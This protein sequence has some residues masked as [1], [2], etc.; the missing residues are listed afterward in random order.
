MADTSVFFWPS[1]NAGC[2]LYRCE[3]PAAALRRRGHTVQVS[4][5]ISGA[6]QI[7]EFDVVV[8]Q[9][10]CEPGPSSIWRDMARWGHSKLVLELDDDMWHLEP[11]NPASQYFTPEVLARLQ[12]NIALAD[13]VTVST[14]ALAE[15][16]SEWND[17]VVVLPNCIEAELLERPVLPVDDVVTIGWAGSPT[18]SRD[19]GEVAKPLRRV[20]QKYPDI[21]EFHCIGADYTDRCASIRGR[22]RFSPWQPMDLYYDSLDFHIGIAPLHADRFNESKSHIKLLEYSALGIAPVVSS[23][24]PYRQAVEQ[25]HP[26]P[27][28][29]T[30]KQ[31][32]EVLEALVTDDD[33]RR[34]L[35]D[36][37]RNWA[38]GY[39]IDRR[40]GEWEEAYA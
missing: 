1:D 28:V 37:A 19:F 17:H 6:A 14:S 29:S 24:G 18:H 9:R 33:A 36:K 34:A 32:A 26:A 35:G 3:M 25:G 12:R 30:P 22:T 8:G 10:L 38:E 23:V 5:I 2:A 31:W 11:S 21:A 15:V 7:G 13:V 16:V 20:L 39:V 4:R 27:A 40:I